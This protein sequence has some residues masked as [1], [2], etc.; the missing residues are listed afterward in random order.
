MVERELTCLNWFVFQEYLHSQYL[1]TMNEKRNYKGRLDVARGTRAHLQSKEQSGYYSTEQVRGH[2]LQQRQEHLDYTTEWVN[3]AELPERAHSTS[4][5]RVT[6]LG[7]IETL[8]GGSRPAPALSVRSGGSNRSII[9]RTKLE[10]ELK[11]LKEK[12][13]LDQE[14]RELQ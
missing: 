14:Q 6:E 7:T 10:L 5:V 3:S 11:H 8:R 9:A 2:F 13:K 1:I 4:P 12:Q